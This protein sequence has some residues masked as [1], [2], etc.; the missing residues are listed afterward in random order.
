MPATP[1]KA[2]GGRIGSASGA[3]PGWVVDHVK[4]LACGGADR[5]E[6]MQWQTVA[7]AK[8]SLDA[9]F[10]VDAERTDGFIKFAC[11]SKKVPFARDVVPTIDAVHFEV[12][13][14]LFEF[15]KS[16]GISGVAP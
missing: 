13:R 9:Y 8:A 3:C 4:A 10:T 15:I 11:D 12:F 1:T 2:R 7:D 16:K 14:P 6:N 5:S